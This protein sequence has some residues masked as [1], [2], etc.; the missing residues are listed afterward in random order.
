[1]TTLTTMTPEQAEQDLKKRMTAVKSDAAPTKG[2]DYS[3]PDIA[4]PQQ[5]RESSSA[6]VTQSAGMMPI[7]YKEPDPPKID[8]VAIA[9][10]DMNRRIG[11]AHQ[12][13]KEDWERKT[14]APPEPKQPAGPGVVST[15]EQFKHRWEHS[16]VS[17]LPVPFLA[18][19]EKMQDMDSLLVA[20]NTLKAIDE[21]GP[22]EH[23]KVKYRTTH[24][25]EHYP[26]LYKLLP[27]IANRMKYAMAA[28]KK[29]TF[30]ARLG[31]GIASAQ[32][33]SEGLPG[34]ETHEDFENNLA[35]AGLSA[36]N[37]IA[38]FIEEAAYQDREKALLGQA[39]TG[40]VDLVPYAL[41]FYLTAGLASTAE[42]GTKKAF[43]YL[44]AKYGKN[45]AAKYGLKAAEA[46]TATVAK[47]AIRTATVGVLKVASGTGQRAMDKPVGYQ[48]GK[49]IT[50]AGEPVL[51]AFGKSLGDAF[52]EYFS[53][54]TGGAITGGLSKAGKAILGKV[55]GAKEYVGRLADAL[56]KALPKNA[57]TTN[58]LKNI[59]YDGLIG[60]LGEERLGD[61]LRSVTGVNDI[62][63]L[64]ALWP[65]WE[66]ILVEAGVLVFPGAAGLATRIP[67]ARRRA[68]AGAQWASKRDEMA[69]NLEE[70]H[71]KQELAR[72]ADTKVSQQVEGS[73][74]SRDN[75][76]ALD[77]DARD[78]VLAEDMA[79]KFS[80]SP[81][82]ALDAIKRAKSRKGEFGDNLGRAIQE[83]VQ[84][85]F[86]GLS[87]WTAEHAD[88]AKELAGIEKPSRSDF[89]RLGLPRR[90][91]TDRARIAETVKSFVADTEAKQ[92]DQASATEKRAEQAAA[93]LIAETPQT[94]D[95]QQS[96]LAGKKEAEAQVGR[97]KEIDQILARSYELFDE[98]N[99]KAD[100]ST[101]LDYGDNGEVLDQL[102][103]AVEVGDVEAVRTLAPKLEASLEAYKTVRS[104]RADKKASRQAKRKGLKVPAKPKAEKIKGPKLKPQTPVSA[105]IAEKVTT[106]TPKAE[107][108]AEKPA[109][110]SGHFDGQAGT[111]KIGRSSYSVTLTDKI[112]IPAPTGAHPKA[113]REV[114]EAIETESH[115]KVRINDEANF[116][117]D[118]EQTPAKPKKK[119]HK[120]SDAE[121]VKKAERET[122]AKAE[123]AEV[124]A[125]DTTLDRK[126]FPPV[127]TPL[128]DIIANDPELPNFK[129]GAEAKTGVIP[130]Q[131][132]KG[133]YQRAGENPIMIWERLDGQVLVATGR[134]RFDLAKRSGETTIL[135]QRIREADGWTLDRVKQLDAE[136]NI[137]DEKG[138]VKDYARYFKS[139]QNITK[140]EA[141][142]DGLTSREKGAQGFDIARS[143]SNDVY[144]AFQGGAI[145]PEKAA[146]IAREAPGD[147]RLQGAALAT[148][149][150]LRADAIPQFIRN[151]RT[152]QNQKVAEASQGS[153]F[154][155]DDSAIRQSIDIAT[156]AA[157]QIRELRKQVIAVE[158]PLKK[159][160]LA[161]KMGL[162]FEDIAKTKAD[163]KALEDRI[164]RLKRAETDPEIFKELQ[165]KVGA[166]L[167]DQAQSEDKSNDDDSTTGGAAGG[168]MAAVSTK[169]A[170][171]GRQEPADPPA[172]VTQAAEK[173]KMTDSELVDGALEILFP[174][175]RGKPGKLASLI[176]RGRTG[177]AAQM[178]EV[179]RA[180]LHKASKAFRWM[181][182]ADIVDFIDRM[183]DPAGARPQATPELDSIAKLLREMLDNG[184]ER[185]QVFGVLEDY[186]ENYFPH[187]F[188]RP[189]HAGDVIAG[190]LSKRRLMPKGFLQKRK[191]LTIKDA[192]SA[193]LEN[194]ENAGLELAHYN[195]VEM[196]ILR[197]HEM[198]RYVAGRQIIADLK[199]YGLIVFVPSSLETNYKRSGWEFV[200]DVPDLVVNATP[201][202]TASEAYDQLLVDQLMGV[203]SRLG[204]SHERV[205]KMGG[206]TWGK[207]GPGKHIKTRFAGPVSVLA[208]EIGHQ[209]GDQFGL[210]EHMLHGEHT[211]G[212]RFKSG[213]KAGQP[214]KKDVT[215]NRADIRREFQ[216]LADLRHEGMKVSPSRQAYER[217]QAEK[218]AVIL[219]AW[220]AAPEKMAE[221]A[222]KITAAWKAFLSSNED[223]QPLLHLDRSV[224]LGS[225][226]S[227]ISQPGVL[228]LGK[229]ALPK[230]AATIIRRHLSPGLGSHSN[231]WVRGAYEGFRQ[232]RNW[233]LM[234]S[235][236]L[237]AFHGINVASDSIN[238]HIGMSSQKLGRGDLIGTIKSVA[239]LW[240]GPIADIMTGERVLKAM[241]TAVDE[242]QDPIMRATVE[243]LITAGGRASMDAA[244]RN[245]A[246]S[247][248]T[249]AIRN[250]KFGSIG[251]KV[252]GV[253][254]MP[255]H[256]GMAAF[257]AAAWP[258]MTYEVPHLKLGVFHHLAQDIYKQAAI[259]NWDDVRIQSELA[260]A[261]DNVDNRMGQLCYDN[262]HWNRVAK[263]VIMLIFRAP[264]WTLGSIREF[265]GGALDTL[266]LPARI[267]TDKDLITRR[268]G[269]A[270]GAGISY[271]IQGS[272]LQY[273]MTGL[274]GDPQPPEEAKD[275]YFPRTGRKNA[276]GSD[277]RLSMPH[278]SKDIVA[279]L[280]SPLKTIQHKLNPVWGTL[281]DL[282][283]NEDYFGRTIREGGP[284]DQAKQA[285]EYFVG[286]MFMPF[287]V[288]N[289]TK[290]RENGEEFTVAAIVGASGISPAPAYITRSLAQKRM[291]DLLRSRSTGPTQDHAKAEQSDRRRALIRNLRS[292]KK[293]TTEQWSGFSH[294]QRQDIE[295]E[296]KKTAFEASFGRL[297]FDES[298]NVFMVATVKE[299]KQIWPI[300]LAKRGRADNPSPESLAAYYE[301]KLDQAK[302]D[303]QV[304]G[305]VQVIRNAAWALSDHR[306]APGR[307]E[308]LIQAMRT[309]PEYEDDVQFA[310]AAFRHRWLFKLDGK[311]SGRKVGSE[312]YWKRV[313]QL[314][315]MMRESK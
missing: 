157:K 17:L 56:R 193:T 124:A 60:E 253:A 82:N 147:E 311:R 75:A 99:A 9:V 243:A 279:W 304:A 271:A 143:A 260:G 248:I 227:D 59:R 91:G 41:E 12:M 198:N 120:A 86:D 44:L 28:E 197:L 54:E 296:A 192:L 62:P 64:K 36:R 159:P 137:R 274:N 141:D 211:V 107:K 140:A 174:A 126:L 98:T 146:A 144:A 237:S 47:G 228:E 307:R 136:A 194:G 256:I 185:V 177:E 127:Q 207:S 172:R 305:E 73:V 149:G 83:E 63:I 15:F 65:G 191:Y 251:Q 306:T 25:E 118:A 204:V 309:N 14:S 289:Y 275:L 90:S 155:F 109:D 104:A 294:R 78:L 43:S 188:K 100:N 114:W 105:P 232:L 262:L 163:V 169:D 222:P 267:G 170:Y 152:L 312:A 139:A 272:I 151:L 226:S 19:V 6:I 235:H 224:V 182:P 220:L 160:E 8:P 254:V 21:I 249:A 128:A 72:D 119:G 313:R 203:A 270:L 102:A 70:S 239:G 266:T 221:V 71:R 244:Y 166:T 158:Q 162:S 213:K 181:A 33:E 238:S 57:A 263:E 34:I 45:V 29:N 173:S 134:H 10:A 240:K 179:I 125:A 84:V 285:A 171:A 315:K 168:N 176:V 225:R 52:I 58:L 93:D 46:I 108:V 233:T 281:V 282:I 48:D 133:K 131:R 11:V 209:I 258:I 167:F 278:Y 22:E 94:T 129:E 206:H 247:A 284:V 255:L 51:T 290:L 186:I 26:D 18:D 61:V 310:V 261:W 112:T 229:W 96:R 214:I 242:I 183:E 268:M 39:L 299:Q 208:H 30:M 89:E 130:A 145:G 205:V 16:P 298:V 184:R 69:F 115:R 287:S 218:E 293:I 215:A 32:A 111:L 116:T 153:L 117:P 286:N 24:V 5:I 103:Q 264:G 236:G 199:R 49:L 106:E 55:P 42:A 246:A 250:I 81:E 288:R 217:K 252:G 76:T 245:N 23:P 38:S 195:P 257:E 110:K 148:A 123:K 280:T 190:L 302:S 1:M 27:K 164:D 113:T 277:E 241:R 138:S 92:A 3:G 85:S 180:K 178:D 223:L 189:K 66:Q 259:H 230:A 212:R 101:F 273:L 200:K 295:R 67:A 219:E 269:Y 308:E 216:A 283:D 53:E 35:A 2:F 135:A 88:K 202:V 265:G 95:D 31:Y 314:M 234:I 97:T 74:P 132:L 50:V 292:G 13:E 77:N 187:L 40:V 301:L 68:K 201:S 291:I 196:V 121:A 231:I 80:I 154:G 87:A 303:D 7:G 156:E 297:S 300:V 37:R 161:K 165:S 142:A 4:T 20:M 210:F 276:D 150:K 79:G 122:P 175:S